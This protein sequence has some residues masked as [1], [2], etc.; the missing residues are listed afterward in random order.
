MIRIWSRDSELGSSAKGPAFY[1]T[2]YA[3]VSLTQLIKRVNFTDIP[4]SQQSVCYNVDIGRSRSL[5]SDIYRSGINDCSLVH[6]L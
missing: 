2:I 4:R 6:P 1:I 5:T 3:I